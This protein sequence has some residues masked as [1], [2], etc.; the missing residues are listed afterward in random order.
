MLLEEEMKNFPSNMTN[1]AHRILRGSPSS[2]IASQL[3]RASRKHLNLK[4]IKD[5]F[6]FSVFILYSTGA[7]SR[8]E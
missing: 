5:I 2:T 4:N 6:R 3:F 8:D 7:A 1:S